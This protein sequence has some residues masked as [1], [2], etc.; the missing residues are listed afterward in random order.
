MAN[1]NL[2]KIT[3]TGPFSVPLFVVLVSL[4]T[5]SSVHHMCF[6]YWHLT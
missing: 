5:D 1:D 4:L 3:Q 6:I 2:D